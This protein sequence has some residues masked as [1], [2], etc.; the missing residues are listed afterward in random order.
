MST[1]G[2][3]SLS[4]WNYNLIDTN[5]WNRTPKEFQKV[6]L[7]KWYPIGMKC[8]MLHKYNGEFQTDLTINWEVSGYT[9]MIYGWVL[10]LGKVDCRFF[11]NKHPLL[12]V[13]T[14]EEIRNKK[15]EKLL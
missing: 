15:L 7:E 9:E 11:Y 6:L 14:K 12:V 3:K 10:K 4:Y 1:F 2:K 13:Q 5:R 8:H